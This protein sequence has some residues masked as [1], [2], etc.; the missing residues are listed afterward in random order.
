[1]Y[2]SAKAEYA[3]LAMMELAARYESSHPV[4][5]QTIAESH[6]ISGRFLVQ[7]LLQLKGAGLVASTRGASGGYK[8]GRPPEDITLADVVRRID[9]PQADDA[10]RVDAAAPMAAVLQHVWKQV[11]AAERDI[12]ESTTLA[13]LVRRS[14]EG[15]SLNYSI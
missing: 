11:R 9:R 2:L 6:D 8:L 3:C 1:M 5:L 10:S 14:R 12:L 13:E 7:I 15:D 4:R